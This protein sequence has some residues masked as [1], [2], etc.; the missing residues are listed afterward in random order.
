MIVMVGMTKKIS[1]PSESHTLCNAADSST[2][3]CI[4]MSEQHSLPQRYALRCH[5]SS[6]QVPWK[7][8]TRWHQPQS[9]N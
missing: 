7:T 4:H 6:D 1:T 2:N 8:P 5:R 9:P 3:G